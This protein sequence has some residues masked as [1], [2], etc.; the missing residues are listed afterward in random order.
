MKRSI[1]NKRR[2]NSLVIMSAIIMLTVLMASGMFAKSSVR[3]LKADKG[4]PG[5]SKQFEIMVASQCISGSIDA[6]DPD[7]NHPTE[8]RN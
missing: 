7:F 1:R 4:Q 3:A 5:G 6:A 8:S 2:Q